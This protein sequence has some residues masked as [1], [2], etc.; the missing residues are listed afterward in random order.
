MTKMNRDKRVVWITIDGRDFIFI[1][2]PETT[3][4]DL[5]KD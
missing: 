2:N 5:S 4:G 1:K 3:S